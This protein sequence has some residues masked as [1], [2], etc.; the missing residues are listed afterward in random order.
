MK[1]PSNAARSCGGGH[2]AQDITAVPQR[3]G[4]STVS[5]LARSVAELPRDRPRRLHGSRSH[6]I[7]HPDAFMPPTFERIFRTRRRGRRY[8]SQGETCGRPG[9][10]GTAPAAGTGGTI[11]HRLN[12]ARCRQVSIRL[13]HTRR[14]S[15]ASGQRPN[16]RFP[17]RVSGFFTLASDQRQP[18]T[19]NRTRQ[20]PQNSA[21]LGQQR[22]QSLFDPDVP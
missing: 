6:Y 22:T 15:A 13:S 8:R 12:A 18:Y 1:M 2:T 3:P 9:G 20:N 10:V 16:R 17:A 4:H 5:T 11:K 21:A 14:Q 7:F 19:E